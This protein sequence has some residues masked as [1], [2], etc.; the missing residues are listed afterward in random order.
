METRK[1]AFAFLA[2]MAL[3]SYSN[4]FV[5][6]QAGMD[7][8]ALLQLAKAMSWE[9]KA[10]FLLMIVQNNGDLVKN[11]ILN[12]E[13]V[14]QALQDF[15]LKLLSFD[16]PSGVLAKKALPWLLGGLRTAIPSAL[17]NQA[18]LGILRTLVAEINA[19]GTN[20]KY[21][22]TSGNTTLDR[23]YMSELI[24]D[25]NYLEI[26]QKVATMRSFRDIVPYSSTNRQLDGQC[27]N[28]TMIFLD[29]LFAGD[30]WALDSKYNI[31]LQ[32]KF[33]SLF[34]QI[35]MTLRNC[36]LQDASY[37]AASQSTE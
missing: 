24:G 11:F 22:F 30:R 6:A 36:G 34:A 16:S 4:V 32:F 10:N 12:N 2:C 20:P 27:Y 23:M 21:N 1:Y 7:P 18:F 31:E 25:L 33:V 29:R 35:N 8:A 19:Q 26:I 15:I 3:Y 14:F 28:D 13:P 9:Q 5:S 37:S 17:D